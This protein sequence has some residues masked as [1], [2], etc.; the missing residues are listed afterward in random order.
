MPA[1]PQVPPGPQPE[2]TIAHPH[3]NL[4][5]PGPT[6]KT[7]RIHAGPNTRTSTDYLNKPLAE[8]G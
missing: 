2:A 6:A 4:H 1:D 5:I 8:L 3:I 7:L